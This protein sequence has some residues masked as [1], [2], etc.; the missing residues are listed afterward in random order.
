LNYFSRGEEEEGEEEEEEEEEEGEEEDMCN[1]KLSKYD[2]SN[3][4]RLFS[5]FFVNT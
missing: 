1:T 4:S 5:C 2:S 3:I